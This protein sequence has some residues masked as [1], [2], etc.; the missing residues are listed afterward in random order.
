MLAVIRRSM[1]ATCWRTNVYVAQF[2]KDTLSIM[3]KRRV[4]WNLHREGEAV[5]EDG[6]YI[7]RS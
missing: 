3:E 2:Q 5:L 4:A 7:K 1:H 6:N